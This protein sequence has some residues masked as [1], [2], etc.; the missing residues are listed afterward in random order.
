MRYCD[1]VEDA[2]QREVSVNQNRTDEAAAGALGVY[3]RYEVCRDNRALVESVGKML[4]A[5]ENARKRE[6]NVQKAAIE[7]SAHVDSEQ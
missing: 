5:F 7:S 2:S 6:V 1:L 3:I 4:T